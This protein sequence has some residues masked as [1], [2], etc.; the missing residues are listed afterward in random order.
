VSY[1]LSETMRRLDN[2]VRIGRVAEADYPRARIRVQTGDLVTDWIPWTATRAGADRSWW[3][4]EIGEQ[5]LLLAPGGQLED[6]VALPAL[7]QDAHDA[8][9]AS[10]DLM[11]LA[12]GD[13]AFVTYDRAAHKLTVNTPGQ[14]EVTAAR[15]VLIDTGTTVTI[16]AAS[17]TTINS[18][19][20]LLN[21]DVVTTGTSTV[22]KVI[23]AKAG[24]AASGTGPG[25]GGATVTIDVPILV[26]RAASLRR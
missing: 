20:I 7:Y 6:T 4:P 1:E 23:N 25:G 18:P 24:L 9:Q 22:Q 17:K 3:A 13:G 16:N 11:H 14:V 5:V 21:G 19:D 26:R 12:F 8:P 15:D 10:P 2:L